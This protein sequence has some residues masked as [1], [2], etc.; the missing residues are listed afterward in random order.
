MRVLIAGAGIGGLTTALMLHARGI[1]CQIWESASQVREVGVGINILPHAIARFESLGLLEELDRIA[2]RT[3][4]L[5]YYTRNGQ[6]VWDEP[7]G[8][9]AGHEVPQFSIH[10]GRLQKTLHDAVLARLGPDSIRCGRRLA[11][12]VQDEAGVT[13]QF[14]DASEGGP[15]E[16]ARGDVLICADGIHSAGRKQFY[17]NEGPPSWNGVSMWRG[18]TLAP[19]WKRGTEMAIGGGFAA[20]LVL[21]P[22]APPEADGRQL[23]N[24]V[25]NVRT[26]DPAVSPP[27]PDNWSRRVGHA[28][29]LPFARRFAIPDYDIEALVRATKD[30]FEYPMADRDPLPRW[31]FGRVTLLGDAA[32][33]MYPVGSNGASQAVLDAQCLADAL[34]SQPHPRAG[35]WAY[36]KERRS[37]TAEVVA[38]NRV[39]GPEGVIDAVE[40]LAPAGFE[41]IDAVLPRHEREALVKGYAAMAG[42]SS[43]RKV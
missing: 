20:K 16:I 32:H 22:I 30:I 6:L 1:P 27:P 36:E 21:Y 34:K 29:V 42:F 31:T 9:G 23:M 3:S 41:D 17:R 33:P 38:Q 14:L 28:T 15:A 35:L 8:L 19:Q 4:H 13:A 11:G 2:V 7:R 40:K 43:V 18:A 10:R 25:V 24:W 26:K 37:K 12:F 5:Y 39:G